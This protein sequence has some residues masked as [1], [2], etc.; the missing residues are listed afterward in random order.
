MPEKGS[1]RSDISFVSQDARFFFALSEPKRLVDIGV[2]S[3]IPLVCCVHELWR[4]DRMKCLY[5]VIKLE[6]DIYGTETIRNTLYGNSMEGLVHGLLA[7]GEDEYVCKDF[8][9][10]MIEVVEKQL[11]G[12]PFDHIW[13]DKDLESIE[14]ATEKIYLASHMGFVAGKAGLN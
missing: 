7:L 11:R 10:E 12:L 14:V 1:S 8:L 4:I 5:E 3:D 13:D 2:E 6:N 9:A